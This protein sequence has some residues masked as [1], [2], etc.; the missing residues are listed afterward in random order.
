MISEQL[1]NRIAGL[2]GNSMAGMSQMGK[3]AISNKEMEIY[4]QASGVINPIDTVNQAKGAIS[5]KEMA[6][7]LQSNEMSPEEKQTVQELLQRAQQVGAA[8]LGQIAKELAMQGE[9]DDTQ[10]AHLRAGEVVL[11]PEFFEDDK[12]ESAVEKKFKELGIN[13][14]QLSL[15][16]I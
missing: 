10:L 1:Q 13:P 9:G 14:E 2:T 16:H 3:G 15:I 5:D 12:F 7:F 11:P 8:P 6:M 4:N